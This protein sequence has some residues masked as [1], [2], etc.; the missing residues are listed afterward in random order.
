ME[1]GVTG[2]YAYRKIYEKYLSEDLRREDLVCTKYQ[3]VNEKDGLEKRQVF[4]RNVSIKSIIDSIGKVFPDK[5]AMKLLYEES[6][7]INI[8]QGS[9]IGDSLSLSEEK[10]SRADE[11][12]SDIDCFISEIE[13]RDE[14]LFL[15]PVNKVLERISCASADFD[16]LIRFL[17]ST[18]N[19]GKSYISPPMIT[20]A[21][22]TMARRPGFA[23]GLYSRVKYYLDPGWDAVRFRYLYRTEF[24]AEIGNE[25]LLLEFDL[26][27][28]IPALH[29]Y[30]QAYTYL[31]KAGNGV[32]D[33]SGFIAGE[34]DPEYANALR[35]LAVLR[36]S[37]DLSFLFEYGTV[38]SAIN[39]RLRENNKI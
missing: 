22:S 14:D 16:F 28:G 39:A 9:M 19:F 15:H 6:F 17:L 4:E 35:K 12:Y 5:C 10:M 13:E 21:P 34:T 27:Q 24:A 18:Q 38:R 32:L 36:N 26:E 7:A 37:P 23:K 20:Q 31:R 2:D 30:R 11:F 25:K 3:I 33:Q 1:D 8:T 29:A